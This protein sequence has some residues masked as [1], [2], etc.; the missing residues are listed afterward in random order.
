MA[1]EMQA[2][3]AGKALMAIHMLLQAL[4][5]EFVIISTVCNGKLVAFLH[6][7]YRYLQA[8]MAAIECLLLFQALVAVGGCGRT[9]VHHLQGL[10]SSK[11]VFKG[12]RDVNDCSPSVVSG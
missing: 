12:S 5:A 11:A 10:K 6:I 3:M 1:A 4:V 2:F 9:G 8:L 7:V